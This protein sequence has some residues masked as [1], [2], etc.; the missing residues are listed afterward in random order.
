MKNNVFQIKIITILAVSIILI[1]CCPLTFSADQT[2]LPITSARAEESTYYRVT[3]PCNLSFP[4]DHGMHPGYR[5]EW[6]YYTGNLKAH[7]GEKFGFQMTIFRSQISPPGAEKNWPSPASQWR[8]Q[9]IFLGHAAVS[10]LTAHQHIFDEQWSREMDGIAGVSQ[11]ESGTTRIYLNKWSIMI[12]EKRHNVRVQSNQFAF[13]L[14]MRSLK[15][16]VLHGDQGYSRKGELDESASCYYSFS[17]LMTDGTLVYKDQT[18]TVSGYSW[19]DHEFST[20]PL[21][22]NIIG[23]DWFSLQFSDNTELMVF[24]LRQAEKSHHPASSGSYIY[25]DGTKKHLTHKDFNI[26]VLDTWKSPQS[27]AGYP[28]KWQLS[29]SDMDM[30]ITLASNIKN[31]EMMTSESTDV[32]YWEGSVAI[33]GHKGPQ[34]ISGFGYVELTGYNQKFDA[35]L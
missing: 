12:D 3:R 17:R 26:K 2:F 22:K 10:N 30:E 1:V 13:D 24:L 9:N 16:A 15:P 5:T 28:S 14:K 35:P 31:Q 25:A 18:Y 23:W 11:N 8:S 6:W 19:M 33:N 4:D 20:A 27:G 29:I 7:T 32:I 34:G 21:Q